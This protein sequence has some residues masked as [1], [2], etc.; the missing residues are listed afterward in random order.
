VGV[1]VS[2]HHEDYERDKWFSSQVLKKHGQLF[3]GHLGGG[4]VILTQDA[5]EDAVHVALDNMAGVDA[6]YIDK[7]GKPH[8]IAWRAQRDCCFDTF[9]IR[10]AR[11]S[12]MST[13]HEKRK[14][15]IVNLELLAPITIH[16]YVRAS[17]L[18][19][20]SAGIVATRDLYGYVDRWMPKL[21]AVKSAQQYRPNGRV[22][23]KIARDGGERLLCVSW[24]GL[25]ED[26]VRVSIIP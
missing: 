15:E 23:F 22:W 11:P 13:E 4:K 19:L 18:E 8:G 26:G 6:W 5:L 21:L 7:S 12:G 14:L 24:A 16:A 2:S 25:V 9:T 1:A 3:A 17:N 10:N 20:L